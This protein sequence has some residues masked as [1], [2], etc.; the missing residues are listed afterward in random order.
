MFW[1]L[2]SFVQRY[3]FQQTHRQ[4]HHLLR[5]PP[6]AVVLECQIAVHAQRVVEESAVVSYFGAVVYVFVGSEKSLAR[7]QL[8][9]VTVG[10][11]LASERRV[12]GLQILPRI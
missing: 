12:L 11:S 1:V 2:S 3:V 8:D 9:A 6:R 7:I 10:E 5:T 4:L